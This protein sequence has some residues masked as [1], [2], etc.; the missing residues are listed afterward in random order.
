MQTERDVDW[1]PCLVPRGNSELNKGEIQIMMP[2]A[3]SAY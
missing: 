2:E 1:E 3:L